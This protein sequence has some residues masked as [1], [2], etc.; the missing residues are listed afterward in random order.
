VIKYC[1]ELLMRWQAID[2]DDMSGLASEETAA[3]KELIKSLA[4]AKK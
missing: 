1:P 3:R 2:P 4:V